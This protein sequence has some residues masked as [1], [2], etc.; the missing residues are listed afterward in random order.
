M[1]SSG[2][3]SYSVPF[4]W[5]CSWCVVQTLLFY[6]ICSLMTITSVCLESLE[7]FLFWWLWFHLGGGCSTVCS[8]H[9]RG[10]RFPYSAFGGTCS[11]ILCPPSD[12][13]VIGQWCLCAIATVTCYL[14]HF[15]MHSRSDS[16]VLPAALLLLGDAVT[17]CDVWCSLLFVVR[18]LF[19]FIPPTDL[20]CY[21]LPGTGGIRWFPYVVLPYRLV[22]PVGITIVH[23]CWS[24]N[25]L[26]VCRWNSFIVHLCWKCY[27][28][29]LSFCLPWWAC[30]HFCSALLLN[31]PVP[32]PGITILHACSLLMHWYLF[33]SVEYAFLPVLQ[34]L[35][36]YVVCCWWEVCWITLWHCSVQVHLRCH[37][38]FGGSCW[39]LHYGGYH[40]FL[41]LLHFCCT[42]MPF[43]EFFYIII[44]HLFTMCITVLLT[45]SM[46]V[47]WCQHCFDYKL[48]QLFWNDADDHSHALCSV[49]GMMMD[50]PVCC[51]AYRWCDDIS[52]FIVV[53]PF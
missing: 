32:Y 44:L 39:R 41:I 24:R 53:P 23:Y 45:C 12:I 42:L 43:G 19:S 26:N 47:T 38:F 27:H 50:I 16:A 1:H 48:L 40:L 37:L 25:S 51:S 17:D 5:Y 18:A 46:I 29:L 49:F 22:L 52:T 9:Y 4:I 35:I 30:H 15:L 8:T 10:W 28:Y 31:F 14:L 36:F 21:S 2:G 13:C 3:M 6:G 33:C 34:D 7:V 11:A 20:H